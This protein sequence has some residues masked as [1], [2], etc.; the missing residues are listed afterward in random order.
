M[1]ADR[2]QDKDLSKAA[3]EARCFKR[4]S[5]LLFSQ[6]LSGKE[7]PAQEW[8]D[9]IARDPQLGAVAQLLVW[10][11]D[12]ST[13]IPAATA[14]LDVSGQAYA[15]TQEPIR[16]AH[17][18]EMA[19]HE[20]LAWQRYFNAHGLK[21]PFLQ[22]WEPV[23][24][25][26]SI[27][28]D[29]YLGSEQPLSRFTG[30]DKHGIH[31]FGIEPGSRYFGF[32]MNDCELEH[33]A[34]ADQLVGYTCGD[35]VGVRFSGMYY[36]LGRFSFSR[37]TRRVNHI[38]ALLDK[39]TLVDRIREDDLSIVHKLDEFT[40]AQITGFIRVAQENGATKVL[41]QLLDYKNAHFADFDPMEEFA[42]E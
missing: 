6:F 21:Q 22:I 29:R 20:V 10:E 37:Y 41:A 11:Q 33:F 13:F 40:L 39:W 42:L 35:Y 25:P 12:G 23:I 26:A 4:R 24:D 32:L 38:V 36:T 15:I 19:P 17:P 1:D 30:N 18:M 28:E 16:V 8:L 3:L 7:T 14:A 9:A 31:P 5:E 2:S 27:H 34:N